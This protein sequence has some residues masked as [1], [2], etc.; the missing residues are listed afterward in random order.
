MKFCRALIWCCVRERRGT[1]F[2]SSADFKRFSFVV[3][4]IVARLLFIDPES[5]NMKST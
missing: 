1:D 4:V 3:L 5:L 2:V